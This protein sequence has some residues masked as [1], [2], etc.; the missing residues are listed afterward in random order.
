LLSSRVYAFGVVRVWPLLS[1][2]W[3]RLP[4]RA[5]PPAPHP[6]Q[7]HPRDVRTQDPPHSLLQRSLRSAALLVSDS[8]AT[9]FWRSVFRRHA[10]PLPGSS[11]EQTFAYRFTLNGV[12]PASLCAASSVLSFQQILSTLWA[13]SGAVQVNLLQGLCVCVCVCVCVHVCM[14]VCV[15]VCMYV[16][17][18]VCACVCMCVC[19]CVCVCVCMCM[20]I[21]MCVCVWRV[22]VA[23]IVNA[24]SHSSFCL[25]HMRA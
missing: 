4:H 21:Y 12:P 10:H 9:F 18:H 20:H 7:S 3:S 22:L 15:H 25:F 17:V 2:V 8:L 11:H 6:K 19:M 1:R 16:C 24:T 5:C 14:Y 23:D 13:R